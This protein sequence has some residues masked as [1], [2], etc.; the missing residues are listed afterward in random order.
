MQRL[1]VIRG[2]KKSQRGSGDRHSGEVAC[3]KGDLEAECGTWMSK[4]VQVLESKSVEK[5]T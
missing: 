3:Q 5:L 2:G 4:S 1:V